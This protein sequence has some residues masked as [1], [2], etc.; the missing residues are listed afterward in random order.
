[1]SVTKEE[2]QTQK[3]AVNTSLKEAG[4]SGDIIT[5]VNSVIKE[6]NDF[7][8]QGGVG[9]AYE[10]VEKAVKAEFGTEKNSGEKATSFLVRSKG[11]YEVGLRADISKDFEGVKKENIDLKTQL[12]SNP[13]TEKYTSL[14]ETYNKSLT[15]NQKMVDELN[16]K[17]QGELKQY[18]LKSSVSSLGLKHDDANYLGFKLDN[19]INDVSKRDFEV[20]ERDGRIVLRGGES[21]SHKEHFLDEMAKE[22]L[23]EFLPTDP[24][25]PKTPEGR[26]KA[27]TF[28]DAKTK[29]EY[30][31]K[32]RENTEKE[33]NI[34]VTSTSWHK[35]FSAEMAKEEHV[36]A[37]AKL[38]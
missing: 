5:A 23:K 1:M 17:H 13:D 34:N 31:S 4:V 36:N 15:E 3:E 29:A 16:G 7:G 2:L 32:L 38:E 14:Q 21:E 24:K 20:I 22:S 12:K 28:N 35:T 33:F 18:K 27:T 8:Y 30:L 37:L 10:E 11:L 25:S 6:S 26:A 9:I 19:F